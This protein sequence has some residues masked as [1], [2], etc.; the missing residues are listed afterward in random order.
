MPE[1]LPEKSVCCVV[2]FKLFD[3]GGDEVIHKTELE[4]IMA[5]SFA[6]ILTEDNIG[7]IVASTFEEYGK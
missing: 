1:L 2:A 6:N 5:P 3:L 7:E 4:Q